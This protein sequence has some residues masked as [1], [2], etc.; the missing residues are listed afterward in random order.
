M[1][2]NISDLFDHY[3]FTGI[4]RGV[5]QEDSAG[6]VPL[7]QLAVVR[8]GGDSPGDRDGGPLHVPRGGVQPLPPGRWHPGQTGP[9]LRW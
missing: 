9:V 1:L 3:W 8:D 5:G 4:W 6:E 2:L 7:A